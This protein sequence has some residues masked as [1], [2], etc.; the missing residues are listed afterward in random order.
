[1]AKP[2]AERRKKT[3]QERAQ[4]QLD[5]ATRIAERLGAKAKALRTELDE[6]E[7]EHRAALRRQDFLSQH[8]DLPRAEEEQEE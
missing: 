3:P 7:R 5:V 2:K 8:P 1:M 4:E 6:V